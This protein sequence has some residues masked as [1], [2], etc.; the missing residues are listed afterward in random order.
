LLFFSINNQ[1][2]TAAAIISL[3]ATVCN[4]V[5]NPMWYFTALTIF[6]DNVSWLCNNFFLFVRCLLSHKFPPYYAI[7][8]PLLSNRHGLLLQHT[9]KYL[10][11]ENDVVP[12]VARYIHSFHFSYI[13]V[14][15]IVQKPIWTFAIVI[16]LSD[17]YLISLGNL[18]VITVGSFTIFIN[19]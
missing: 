9:C 14:L 6:T 18:H 16:L 3:P 8:C 13:L 2:A 1:N 17:I 12:G 5:I 15:K 4:H 7:V 11:S 19:K 10:L